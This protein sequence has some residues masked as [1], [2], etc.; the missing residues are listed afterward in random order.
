[1]RGQTIE[2]ALG[3]ATSPN[4]RKHNKIVLKS[5]LQDDSGELYCMSVYTRPQYTYILLK[6]DAVAYS[7]GPDLILAVHT[8]TGAYANLYGG[9]WNSGE[10]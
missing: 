5:C 8:N 4:L 9:E 3:R 1:M 10:Y 7:L 6:R 2:S